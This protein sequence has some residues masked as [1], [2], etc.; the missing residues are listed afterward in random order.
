LIRAFKYRFY[1]NNEQEAKL[2]LTLQL[3]CRLYNTALEQRQYAHK[4]G[5]SINYRTQQ[6]Q[7]LELKEGIP[8]YVQVQSQVLQDVLRRVDRAFTNFFDRVERRR[9]GERIATGYPR[10]KPSWRYNSITY[11]QAQKYKIIG[12][13]VTLP[14]IGRLRVFMHRNPMGDIKTMTV[15][16]DSVGDWYIILTMELPTY[17]RKLQVQRSVSMSA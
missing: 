6:N 16:R 10:F 7:L 17:P 12:G 5:R 11:P 2:D 15:K 1:P 14:K 3:C 4:S 13:Q 8:D 9:K